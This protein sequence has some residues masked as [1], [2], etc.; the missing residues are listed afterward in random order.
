MNLND[1]GQDIVIT[2]GPYPG[3]EIGRFQALTGNL[4]MAPGGVPGGSG[5]GTPTRQG[6]VYGAHNSLGAVIPSAAT[7]A[8][9]NGTHHV[10]G[11]TSI[12]NITPPSW[13]LPGMEITLIPDGLWAT[14][15]AGNIYIVSTAV[16]S[17]ALIMTWDGV[18][19]SPSY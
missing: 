5:I 10:S 6:M 12:V 14:T 19:W 3:V 11:V 16:V 7:I 8:P 4:I 9:N 2:T 17:K 13:I 1:E 15:A 18:K